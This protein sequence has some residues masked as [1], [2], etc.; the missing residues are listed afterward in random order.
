MY[1]KLKV[2]IMSPDV[3]AVF[4]H[5]YTNE[6]SAYRHS[7]LLRK[8]EEIQQNHF[9]FDDLAANVGLPGDHQFEQVLEEVIQVFVKASKHKFPENIREWT[10]KELM[11][12]HE[13][14][15]SSATLLAMKA[16]TSEMFIRED[17]V[18]EENE[19]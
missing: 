12:C 18:Y 13:I 19:L 15:E 9:E 4:Y 2:K 8:A 14:A 5:A 10:S 7:S 1:D 11:L 3:Q 6:R 16:Y 17:K